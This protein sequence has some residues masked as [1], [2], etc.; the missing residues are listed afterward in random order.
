MAIHGNDFPLA[1]RDTVFAAAVEALQQPPKPASDIA[2][3]LHVNITAILAA[4]GNI[5]AIKVA[6]WKA[7]RYSPPSSPPPGKQLGASTSSSNSILGALS[8]A[9]GHALSKFTLWVTIHMFLVARH[10]QQHAMGS[11]C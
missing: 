11:Q 5:E 10:N 8:L 3:S 4:A 9:M 2:A 1:R 7:I 6:Y